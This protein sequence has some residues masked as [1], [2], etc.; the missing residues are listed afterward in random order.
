MCT[1]ATYQTK[2]FY[3]GRTL[4]YEFSYGEQ[5]AIMPRNYPLE[6]RHDGKMEKHY[7]IIGSQALRL[8]GFRHIRTC[9]KR[10]RVCHLVIQTLCFPHAI[11]LYRKN[12]HTHQRHHK[13]YHSNHRIH[14]LFSTLFFLFHLFFP[15]FKSCRVLL[16]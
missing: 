3:M 4:D 13:C 1:A 2:D 14:G 7:A 5:I 8:T 10:R 12:R 9:R 6:F 16:S 15:P 11:L